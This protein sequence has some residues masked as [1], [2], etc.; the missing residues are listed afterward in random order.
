MTELSLLCWDRPWYTEFFLRKPVTS[1]CRGGT[2]VILCCYEDL[3]YLKKMQVQGD[4]LVPLKG[5]VLFWTPG[6]FFKFARVFSD[7]T[8]VNVKSALNFSPPLPG[9]AAWMS[10]A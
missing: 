8:W 7:R 9:H 3:S 10:L 6:S 5:P 4:Q 1:F 2:L